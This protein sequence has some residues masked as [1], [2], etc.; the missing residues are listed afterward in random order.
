MRI[1]IDRASK[2]P[3][4]L[5]IEGFLRQTILAGTLPAYS[6]LP[7]ARRL[8]AELGVSRVTVESAYAEL[9]VEGLI[10]RRTGSGSYVNPPGP[11]LPTRREDMASWPLW[12][13]EVAGEAGATRDERAAEA[14]AQRSTETRIAL[15][16]AH[17]HPND[18]ISFTGYGDPLLFRF[19]EF[20]GAIREVVWRDGVACLEVDDDRGY[21]PLRASIAHILT[22]QGIEAHPDDVLV[23]S[24]SQ[25][26]LSIVTQLLLKPGDPVLVESPTYDGAIRLFHA[27]GLR[28]IGCPTDAWGMRVES[29]RGGANRLSR[30]E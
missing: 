29:R 6:R 21:P 2:T 12:Q 24:G 28:L 7:S 18:V 30:S 5:Q 15:R 14:N 19:E 22:S 13:R 20:F 27:H 17:G 16:G 9:E 26:A 8:A 3:L 4:Y 25:Q 23:T 10:V 11:D 1:P